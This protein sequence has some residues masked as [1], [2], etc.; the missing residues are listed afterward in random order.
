MSYVKKI[1]GLLIKKGKKVVAFKAVNKALEKLKKV[2]PPSRL[3]RVFDRILPAVKIYKKKVSGKIYQIPARIKEERAKFQVAKWVVTAI[4]MEKGKK[5]KKLSEKISKVILDL[6]K[7][8]GNIWKLRKQFLSVVKENR[9]YMR[10]IRRRRIKRKKW[11][12]Q[13]RFSNKMYS[14]IQWEQNKLKKK[15]KKE[16]R[17]VK[18]VARDKKVKKEII[19]VKKII[20]NGPSKS[21]K[22]LKK[23]KAR[24]LDEKYKKI[25]TKDKK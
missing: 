5:K 12:F 7:K 24:K 9:S 19:K 1:L 22:K 16:K 25:N 10:F 2:V 17:G 3:E 18:R 15:E 13:P 20:S 23:I 8:R 4:S 21:S 6:A 11:V 14:R